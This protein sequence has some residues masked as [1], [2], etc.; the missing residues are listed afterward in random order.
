MD[1]SIMVPHFPALGSGGVPPVPPT[2]LMFECQAS[3]DYPQHIDLTCEASSSSLK[4]ASSL[5]SSSSSPSQL[6]LIGI[7]SENWH[8]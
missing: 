7:C 6:A 3:L 1:F 8:I 5:S 2:I 4:L